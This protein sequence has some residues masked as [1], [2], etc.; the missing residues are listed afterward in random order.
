MG[1][2]QLG[3]ISQ[4]NNQAPQRKT[5]ISWKTSDS[6]GNLHVNETN[7]DGTPETTLEQVPCIW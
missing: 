4:R 2:R 5:K 1:A 7:V 6:L 3:H